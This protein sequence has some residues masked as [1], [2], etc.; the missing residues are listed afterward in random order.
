M[1]IESNWRDAPGPWFDRWTAKPLS[2]NHVRAVV[3]A[4]T[5]LAE[6]MQLL[7]GVFRDT[8]TDRTRRYPE[9]RWQDLRSEDVIVAFTIG[10]RVRRHMVTGMPAE[11]AALPPPTIR[12]FYWETLMLVAAVDAHQ[13]MTD[14][15][16]LAMMAAGC[17]L[18]LPWLA[19][20]FQ[21]RMKREP[22][23]VCGAV[24]LMNRYLEKDGI[25][26]GI[27]PGPADDGRLLRYAWEPLTNMATIPARHIECLSVVP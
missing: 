18:G 15:L 24:I 4:E 8:L 25:E 26:K 11:I 2:L 22:A 12:W 10:A 1:A 17:D 14:P 23:G 27:T 6:M 3:V 7:C 13:A 20:E 9:L 5:H 19:A 21:R 16:D